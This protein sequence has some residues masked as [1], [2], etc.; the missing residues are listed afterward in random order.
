MA[1]V[2]FFHQVG[3]LYVSPQLRGQRVAF[4]TG[5]AAMG[6][7]S[8]VQPL[9]GLE[10]VRVPQRLS[11]VAAEETSSSVGEHVPTEVWFLGEAQVTLGAGIRFLSTVNPQMRLQVPFLTE[12]L[13]TVLTD[14]RFL[15]RVQLHVVPQRAR[16]SQQLA[17][18]C[19][20]HLWRLSVNPPAAVKEA[21]DAQGGAASK[22]L[23]TV[24]AD[25]RFL[26]GVQDHVLLQV[27]LQAIGLLTVRAGERTLTAVTH[28]M[29]S[30]ALCRGVAPPTLLA[31]EGFLLCVAELVFL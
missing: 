3:R 26:S 30:E 8:S 4:S 13:P 1:G 19:T 7:L 9:M 2:Q 10:A 27:P 12:A 11:T 20:L 31:A 28:L 16:V 24:L 29:C 15:P 25:V 14:V 23:A 22:R 18:D 5:R 21:V 6:S 17:A